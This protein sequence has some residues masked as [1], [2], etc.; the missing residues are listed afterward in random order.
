[1]SL[2]EQTTRPSLDRAEDG[3]ARHVLSHSRFSSSCLCT[4]ESGADTPFK[5]DV[6]RSGPSARLKEECAMCL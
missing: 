4:H 3:L 2:V 6:L 1:M 5:E